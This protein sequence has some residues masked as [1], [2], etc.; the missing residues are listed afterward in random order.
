MHLQI[1]GILENNTASLQLD[2][3]NTIKRDISVNTL[4]VFVKR[5]RTSLYVI[6]I[7]LLEV[8]ILSP[9]YFLPLHI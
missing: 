1:D 2:W 3:C 8:S 4:N 5:P 6:I 9:C 7:V